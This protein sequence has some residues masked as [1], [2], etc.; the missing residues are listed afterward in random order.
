V[1]SVTEKSPEQLPSVYSVSADLN[2][3]YDKQIIDFLVSNQAFMG[4]QIQYLQS[5]LDTLETR[6][7]QEEAEKNRL[8]LLQK[9]RIIR[10]LEHSLN[11]MESLNSQISESERSLKAQLE[12]S[13]K[14][15]KSQQSRIS[16]LEHS[17]SE[18]ESQKSRNS[19][20]E[21]DLKEMED[22]KSQ[23][24]ERAK[25]ALGS[26]KSRIGELESLLELMEDEKSCKI[27][28]EKDKFRNSV[29][30]P[31]GHSGCCY[32][33]AKSLTQPFCP[34]CRHPINLVV[35]IFLM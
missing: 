17:L 8:I 13:L 28:S 34:W 35:K 1:K 32:E 31:C 12:H 21:R 2:N 20:L 30:L 10:E 6:K 19:E 27:C 14:E 26:L 33:C 18:M 15:M 22:Q 5:S 11:Q 3:T 23:L 24:R 16:E 7:S 25:S 4:D 29:F 9:S